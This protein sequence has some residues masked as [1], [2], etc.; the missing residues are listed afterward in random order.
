MKSSTSL[1]SSAPALVT[2]VVVPRER[3]SCTRRSLE[4]IYENTTMPFKLIYVDGNSPAKVRRYLEEQSQA[5]GFKLIRTDYYLVPNQARNIGWREVD[6]PYLVF[7]DN[8]VVVA[9]DWLEKLVQC[10]EATQATI[11]GPLMC[12]NEPVHEIV[13][14]AGG[15][16]RIWVDATGKRR[17]REKIYFQGKRVEDVSDRLKQSPTEMV[18][19]HCM[20]VR[21]S[22][23]DQLGALDESLLNT[24][25]HL[26]FCMTVTQA[27]GTVYLEP[28]SLATYVPAPPLEWTDLH[29]FMLRW[30]DEWELASLKHLREKWD[31]VEDGNFQ[32]RYKRRGWRRYITIFEPFANQITLGVGSRLLARLMGKLDH[33]FLNPYLT[34][35]HAKCQAAKQQKSTLARSSPLTANQSY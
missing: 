7:I 30:S 32:A 26:D 28:E 23:F 35:R 34:A 4:S 12:Q 10:A 16:A 27:G 21:R 25:E 20:L 2:V 1:E 5:K 22:I 18:E 13:H 6:T 24:R 8:D 11:V 17:L 33:L 15:D 19:F 14:V 29:F 9:P 3:F 31:V